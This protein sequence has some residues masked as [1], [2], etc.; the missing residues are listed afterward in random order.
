MDLGMGEA[1]IDVVSSGECGGKSP[2]CHTDGRATE[3]VTVNRMSKYQGQK[4]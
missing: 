1:F 3:A 4:K 2:I